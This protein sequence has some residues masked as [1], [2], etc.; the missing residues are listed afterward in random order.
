MLARGELQRIKV[1]EERWIKIFNHHPG[2]MTV[3]QQEEI[4]SILKKNNFLAVIVPGVAQHSCRD[5][6]AARNAMHLFACGILRIEATPMTAHGRLNL[7]LDSPAVNLI[8][9]FL[10]KFSRC[11]KTTA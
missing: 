3:E 5:Y 4:K 1:P 8:D 10:R 11:S 2:Y 9:R 7:A 6:C